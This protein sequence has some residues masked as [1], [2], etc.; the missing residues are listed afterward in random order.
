MPH[1]AFIGMTMSGKTTLGIQTAR[2]Y[3]S[4]GYAVLVCDPKRNPDWRADWMTSNLLE[5]V[6]VAK[7]STRCALFIEEAGNFGKIPEF[8]WLFT[9][10]RNWGHV[11]H[12]LSQ[13]HRQVPP[14]VR[15][16]IEHLYL[17][18]AGKRCVQEFADEFAQPRIVDL[19]AQ[20]RRHDFV[21]VSRFE[22]AKIQRLE[23]PGASTKPPTTRKK[24]K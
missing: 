16:N 24:K 1:S 20:L 2:G 11:A 7:R 18:T 5:F 22:D 19:V 8:E 6:D 21:R 4:Q 9:E 12:Y 17:F 13:F 14:I 15:G 3:Q 10:S 23:M